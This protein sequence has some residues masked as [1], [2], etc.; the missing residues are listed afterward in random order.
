MNT[1]IIA[2][3]G[4]GSR[5][6]GLGPKQFVELLE[7]PLVVHTLE[8]F[9]ECQAVDE[10]I[11]VAAPGEIARLEK[12]VSAFGIEK[13]DKIV[14]GGDTRAASVLN[15]LNAVRDATEVVTVHDAA[16]PLVAVE[17]ITATLEKAAAF[18]AACLVT[19]ITD[20]IKMVDGGEIVRTLD[21]R[22][23][24]RA[25]TPQAFRTEV[26]RRAYELWEPGEEATDECYLVEKLGHPIAV[27]EGSP[28]NVKVTRVD[29]LLFVE[30][31]MSREFR[32]NR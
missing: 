11:V 23:M 20:T 15:G 16:R 29:D 26:L 17:E 10:I 19:E 6:G 7:K 25:L 22:K 2:A 31:V 5:F 32:A 4:S 12:L 18:G 27:V 8:R 13:I 9:V 28:R 30:S 14:A 1:A 3:A 24:R 21:R